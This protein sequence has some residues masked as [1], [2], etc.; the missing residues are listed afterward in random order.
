MQLPSTDLSN[1]DEEEIA[2]FGILPKHLIIEILNFLPLEDIALRISLVS[3]NFLKISEKD[4]IWSKFCFPFFF[5][6]IHNQKERQKQVIQ[7]AIEA[8]NQKTENT[9]ETKMRCNLEKIEVRIDDE[10]FS[11]KI[12]K[13]YLENMG[14]KKLKQLFIDH[15][16]LNFNDLNDDKNMSTMV[17]YEYIDEK[18]LSWRMI[19]TKQ[20]FLGGVHKV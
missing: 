18:T 12:L 7:N 14:T 5:G 19:C 15:F 13:K 6:Q 8:T 3:K 1:D 2:K 16:V 9:Q 4:Y 10:P 11:I 17:H 20:G